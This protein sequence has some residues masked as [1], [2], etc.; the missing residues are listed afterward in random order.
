MPSGPSA[1]PATATATA[2]S[3]AF[4]APVAASAGP[5]FLSRDRSQSDLEETRLAGRD[6]SCFIVGGE[7]RLCLPQILNIVLDH[8]T[9]PVINAACDDLQIFCSTCTPEQLEKLK[10]AKIIPVAASQCG[11][12]TK[13]DAER[14]CSILLDRSPP[15]ASMSGFHAKSS[16]FSFRVHHTC[17]GTCRG[18]V[19]PEAYTTSTALCIECLE[20]QGLFCP[21]KFVCHSHGNRENRTCHWGFDSANWRSYLLLSDDYTQSEKDKLSKVFNDFKA[22]YTAAKRKQVWSRS[23]FWFGFFLMVQVTNDLNI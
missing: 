21:Q 17:F 4:K 10:L 9:L 7:R 8:I 15:L 18:I 16:P 6:I 5:M 23:K 2:T 12:I 11:L 13:S 22:R 20:C 3:H 14:L 19:L 1:P